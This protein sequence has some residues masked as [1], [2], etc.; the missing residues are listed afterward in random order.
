MI[1]PQTPWYRQALAAPH[2]AY[3]RV[4]V[5]RSG[6][7]V[8]ELAWVDQGAP[9]T[10]GAPIFFGGSVRAS[11]AS[12]VTRTL[13]LTVPSYLYPWN[14]T[15]LLNPYG[16]ELRVFKGVFYGTGTVDEFPAFVGTVEEVSPPNLGKATIK[17][18]DT[19]LRVAAAGFPS[20]MPSQVG[21]P[22]LGE[23]E[24]L[25]L[26]ANPRAVFGVH[27]A[28]TTT[29]PQLS[30]DG[31]RG[32]ALDS[33]AGAAGANW[34][35]LADG[36]YVVRLVPWTQTL[37]GTPLQLSD[38][39]GGTLLTA[40]PVRSASGV[41]NQ[42]TVLSERGDGGA[43]EYAMASDTDPASP[44]Y[45]GGPFGVRSKP[46][47]R[48]TG[49]FNQGQLASIARVE[50]ARSQALTASWQLTCVPDASIELGD[51]L[52]LTYTGR[53]ATQFAISFTMPLRP[54]ASMQIQGRDLVE[55]ST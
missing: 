1:P 4:E 54:D 29:T 27:S 49:A 7:Q 43:A 10:R 28:I 23:I 11:L 21:Y 24:R 41:Y 3:A 38:G 47:V 15:D 14:A 2:Q 20:P 34:Y 37:A 33:L 17:A 42:V 8:D 22:V 31:D 32:Q 40:F 26:D 35:T 39:D 53:R 44:T 55:V 19:A 52:Q 46:A 51:P 48:V 13:D 9:Y 6:V 25:I 50:L 18:S 16:T 5:W 30:Y 36:R 45:I 12:R